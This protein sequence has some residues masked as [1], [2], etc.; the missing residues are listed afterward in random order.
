MPVAQR[1]RVPI[2]IALIGGV[3]LGALGGP[4][5]VLGI[6]AAVAILCGAIARSSR[7]AILAGL[8]FGFVVSLFFLAGG[9]NGA[10]P[11]VTRLPFFVVLALFG[12]GC[13]AVISGLVD[14][15]RRALRR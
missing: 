7:D 12:A 10:E 6:W 1:A 2:A 11:L 9:Y 13:G 5:W 4:V 15:A 8:I 14:L 3:V